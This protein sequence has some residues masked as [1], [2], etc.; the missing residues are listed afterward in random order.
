MLTYLGGWELTRRRVNANQEPGVG[1]WLW[2][3]PGNVERCATENLGGITSMSMMSRRCRHA[4]VLLALQL[5]DIGGATA[6]A[7]LRGYS[8]KGAMEHVK[9]A[10]PQWSQTTLP[11]CLWPLSQ[12][13]FGSLDAMEIC[14][15][16][17]T[18]LLKGRLS[19][20]INLH[21]VASISCCDAIIPEG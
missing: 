13:S 9:C 18:V 6:C 21:P 12:T 20:P 11:C 10:L 3:Y 8:K 14:C 2:S 17:K 15:C 1:V 4:R 19:V 16:C 5:Y 7:G